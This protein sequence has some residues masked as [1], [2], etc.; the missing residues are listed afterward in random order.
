[1]KRGALSH[2]KMFRLAGILG[3]LNCPK[4]K[5]FTCWLGHHRSSDG[6][7]QARSIM[8]SLWYFTGESA[9][10]GDIGAF[11]DGWIARNVSWDGKPEELIAA[12]VE[13]RWLD[14]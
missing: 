10:A 8:A 2:R 5:D 13:A 11:D 3:K 7:H 9:P 1:M 6:L 4:D 12:L 14:P